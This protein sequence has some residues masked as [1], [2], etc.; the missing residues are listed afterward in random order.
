MS[1]TFVPADEDSLLEAMASVYGSP[2]YIKVLVIDE[3]GPGVEVRIMSDGRVLSFPLEKG[4]EHYRS[5]PLWVELIDGA[6]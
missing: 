1:V 2:A 4:V 3:S 5:S 6:T